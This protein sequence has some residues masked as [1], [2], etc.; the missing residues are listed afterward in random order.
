MVLP[1][2]LWHWGSS[3]DSVG[4]QHHPLATIPTAVASVHM[5]FESHDEQVPRA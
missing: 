1:M 2:V 4:P 3:L 5:Q